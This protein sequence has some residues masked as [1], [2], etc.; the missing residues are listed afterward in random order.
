MR[1]GSRWALVIIA[2][3]LAACSTSGPVAPP[4]PAFELNARVA[5]RSPEHAFSSGLRWKQEAGSEEIWFNA[6]LGQTLA[7]VH[8]DGRGATLTAADQKQY[9]AGS[10]E[11]LTRQ[12]L[13]WPFPV[14]AMRYWVL[15]LP[16]PHLAL[17]NAQRDGSQRLTR[18][19][20]GEWKV[21][22]NYPAPDAVRPSRLDISG[23]GLEIRLAIDALKTAAP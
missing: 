1:V 21:A 14:S 2:A 7:Y 18:F 15:G 9:H 12:A 13:G 5:V 20:Q 16:A 3:L 22:L 23:P 6:P 19:D 17:D 4:A 11:S 10:I 8:A